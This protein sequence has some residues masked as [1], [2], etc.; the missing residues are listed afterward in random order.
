MTSNDERFALIF[1]GAIYNHRV[2]REEL[3]SSGYRFHTHCDTEV[4]LNAWHHWGSDALPRLRGMFAFAVWDR[5]QN[6]LTLVRDP[7]EI[8][9]L[10]YSETAGQLLLASVLNALCASRQFDQS[11]NPHAVD[12]FLARLSVPAPETIY[13]DAKSLRP[14]GIDGLARR[15]P[16]FT[17]FLEMPLQPLSR[18]N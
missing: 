11:I 18:C 10:Y 4:L 13:Q 16:P 8:K 6:S 7:L 3:E 2:L 17:S 12:Q 15:G 9:P 14:G 5:S 1:N